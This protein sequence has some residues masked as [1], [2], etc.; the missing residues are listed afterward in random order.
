MLGVG[1][2]EA[3]GC[4]L[5]FPKGGQAKP[6]KRLREPLQRA[7]SAGTGLGRRPSL[8]KS[9]REWP[10]GSTGAGGLVVGRG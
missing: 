4:A 5:E 2:K 7:V 6:E 10:S 3:E 9:L 1:R 8:L